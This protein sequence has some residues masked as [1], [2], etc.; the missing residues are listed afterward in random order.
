L[1]SEPE[2]NPPDTVTSPTGT[3]RIHASRP[4]AM[5][6]IDRRLLLHGLGV[7]VGMGLVPRHLGALP[8][9][10][11]DD[12][13]RLVLVQLSGGN[14]GLSMV[15]PYGDDGYHRVR[16]QIRHDEK[17]VL[18]LDGY[19]GFNKALRRLH[20]RYQEGQLALIEGVG[21]ENPIR[22]HFRSF[23]VWHTADPRGRASGEGWVGKLCEAAFGEEIRP[24]RVVHVGRKPPYSV[25]STTHPALSFSLPR[26][27]RWIEHEDELA[28]MGG[29]AGSDTRTAKERRLAHLRSLMDSAR[30]SSRAV[31]S[32]V[33]AHR[34]R[35]DYPSDPFAD[36]LRS[37]AALVH[38]DLDTRV[39][40]VELGGFDTHADQRNRHQRLM[41][42]LDAGLTPFLQDLETSEAGRKTL[43]L[44]FSEF[45]RRVAENASRGTD[46]G[47]AGPMFAAG[48]PVQ[49]GLYGKHPSL[50][51]LDEGDLVYTTDFRSVYA[52]AI[53]AT[54]SIE[55]ERVLG[56]DYPRLE[57]V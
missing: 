41:E 54:F 21:Y 24:E 37:A 9:T 53:Q 12:E 10:S 42:I 32:A 45:G 50:S 23:D 3:R 46:H 11:E 44:V 30:D 4:K 28:D 8:R 43:V 25:Y 34:P 15:V 18:A 40:S 48:A 38:S 51:E 7:G 13:R 16:K 2:K 20:E 19:R 26:N 47:C 49:G 22:S 35:V 6:R 57:F 17:E 5:H 39:I 31:R 55:P 52:T 29:A 14:D 56:A 1:K 27:Y 33:A 36:S